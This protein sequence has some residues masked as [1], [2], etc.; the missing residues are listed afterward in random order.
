MSHHNRRRETVSECMLSRTWQS[1]NILRASTSTPEDSAQPYCEKNG[2]A[3]ELIGMRCADA[4]HA[5]RLLL[6]GSR[7][8][9][10]P[11]KAQGCNRIMDSRERRE[12]ASTML[13]A[14][15]GI[16]F[17]ANMNPCSKSK[18]CTNSACVPGSFACPLLNAPI[19]DWLSTSTNTCDRPKASVNCVQNCRNTW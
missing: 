9:H 1:R 10:T 18:S 15:V 7:A 2:R 4:V 13:L 3:W 17:N 11:R 6:N 5:M 14:A 12:I 16:H 8:F 19:T